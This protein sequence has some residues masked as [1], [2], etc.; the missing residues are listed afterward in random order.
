MSYS[1][2]SKEC[3]LRATT[4]TSALARV[5]GGK[6]KSHA[7]LASHL[8]SLMV[9]ITFYPI[10]RPLIDASLPPGESA[11]VTHRMGRWVSPRADLG[12]VSK[13]KTLCP[14]KM[15]INPRFSSKSIFMSLFYILQPKYRY[16]SRSVTSP[17]VAY[18]LTFL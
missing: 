4:I 8:I 13:I 9:N 17:V 11:L 10:H 7:V 18:S 3:H 15:E 2:D 14:A 6:Y 12:V 5:R 1:L 16:R